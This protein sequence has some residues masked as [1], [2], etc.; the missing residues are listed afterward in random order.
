MKHTPDDDYAEA[1]RLLAPLFEAIAANMPPSLGYF[2][3]HD[4]ELE[5]AARKPDPDR[6]K[7]AGRVKAP[8][9]RQTE[10][11]GTSGVAPTRSS[12]DPV[13]LRYPH[14]E[15]YWVE[16]KGLVMEYLQLKA[17][18]DFSVTLEEAFITWV[19]RSP[20]E[21]RRYEQGDDI[22]RAAQVDRFLRVVNSNSDRREAAGLTK[23]PK[24]SSA[25]PRRPQRARDEAYWVET[26]RL[27]LHSP[28]ERRR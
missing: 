4:E 14:D 15:A 11:V 13:P 16:T 21:F 25:G 2:H 8:T 28:G 17:G 27:W 1:R 3:D 6:W 26:G 5:Y 23:A 22:L 9:D 19:L 20:A 24:R 18:A 7:A 12:P 10:R